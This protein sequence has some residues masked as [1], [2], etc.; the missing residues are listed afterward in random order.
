MFVKNYRSVQDVYQLLSTS[1]VKRVALVEHKVKNNPNRP[2]VHTLIVLVSHQDF[3]TKIHRCPAKCCPEIG[4]SVYA[5]TE[6][7]ELNYPLNRSRSTSCKRTFSGLRSLW[8]MCY[9]CSRDTAEQ[10]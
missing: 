1:N 10:I 4:I 7:T 6:I 3:G 5:P 9:E 2:D 8:M